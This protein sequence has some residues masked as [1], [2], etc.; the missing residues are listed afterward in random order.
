MDFMIS[1]QPL[2]NAI[3]SPGIKN[4]SK[5]KLIFSCRFYI[6]KRVE[7][8]DTMNECSDKVVIICIDR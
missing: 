3:V 8:S 1:G 5:I 4:S 7:T 6:P 2:S